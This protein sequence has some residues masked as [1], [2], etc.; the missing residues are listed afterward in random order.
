MNSQIKVSIIVPVYNR[1]KYLRQC[2]D[3]IVSQTLKEIEII[4]VDNGSIDRCP[5]ICDEYA[6][7]DSRIRVIHIESNVGIGKAYNTGM[8]VA[9]GEYI[10]FVDSDDWVE[11][12]MYEELYS[13]AL[14]LN[15]DV[16]KS[17]Y[18]ECKENVPAVL[19]NKFGQFAPFNKRLTNPLQTPAFVYGHISMWSAIYRKKFLEQEKIILP[20][21][22]EAF[23]DMVFCWE[24]YVK[25]HSY[26]LLREGFYNYRISPSQTIGLGWKAA[27]SVIR[28][29]ELINEQLKRDQVPNDFKEIRMKFLYISYRASWNNPARLH[30]VRRIYFAKAIANIAKSVAGNIKFTKF[31]N[32]EKIEFL[33]VLRHPVWYGVKHLIYEKENNPAYA[34]IKFSGIKLYEK[35]KTAQCDTRKLLYLPIRKEVFDEQG[36][37]IFRLGLPLIRTTK[38]GNVIEKR[39]LG[40]HYKTEQVSAK[41]IPFANDVRLL[42]IIT[43]ANAITNTH[44]ATFTKYKNCHSGQ[45]VVLVATGP[46]LN[47]YEPKK[48]CVYVGVNKAVLYNRVHFDY[49]FFQ[50]FAHP[51]AYEIFRL[52]GQYE[53]AKKFYGILQ[54]TIRQDWIVPESSAIRDQAERY[55]VISQWKYPPVHFT[56]D[57]ANEPFGDCGSVSFAAMQFALWTNPKQIYLVGQDCT[58]GYWDHSQSA[59]SAL[60]IASLLGGWRELAK[61]A[62]I[63]YPGTEIIS[64][65]PVGLKGIFTDMYTRKHH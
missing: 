55:Y 7:E 6:A 28:S 17:L 34:V 62:R 43:H 47:F 64:I 45:S 29:H 5:Q 2:V 65:N 16:V 38:R 36:S 32:A 14:E 25:M 42:Q 60:A 31:T 40:I 21:T 51:Q 50:D 46:T 8:A 20:S 41:P 3:S 4:L 12:K 33:R 30:G 56:Y 18:W 61:F 58:N 26:C 54:D 52:I 22:P 13:K 10:G 11:S 53:K 27:M 48:D 35:K 24:V 1:E 59:T 37:K 49:L 9:K 15:V 57:I 19:R 63:Y 39:F 44:R 23:Q